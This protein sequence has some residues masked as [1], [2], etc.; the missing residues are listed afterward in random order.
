MSHNLFNVLYFIINTIYCCINLGKTGEKIPFLF[1]NDY[2]MKIKDSE[3]IRR[4]LYG[5]EF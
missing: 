5:I 4:R 3:F 1:L 2:G